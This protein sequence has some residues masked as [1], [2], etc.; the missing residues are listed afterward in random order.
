MK[1]TIRNINLSV[2]VILLSFSLVKADMNSFITSVIP[3]QNAIDINKATNIAITFSQ[4]MNTSTF[5]SSNIKIYGALSGYNSFTLSS[6][7]NSVT[8]NPDSDFA[9]GEDI[10][11]ILNS[12]I[13]SLS[14]DSLTPFGYGFTV[15]ATQGQS[16]FYETRLIK[17]NILQFMTS[18]DIDSDGDIDILAAYNKELAPLYYERAVNVYKRKQNGIYE[19]TSTFFEQSGPNL[20]NTVY[21]MELKDMD[22]DGFLDVVGQTGG[23][24]SF[25]LIAYNDGNGNFGNIQTIPADPYSII[26]PFLIADFD[27]DGDND[28]LNY[29]CSY[30]MLTIY[31]NAGNHGFDIVCSNLIQIGNIDFKTSS[32]LDNDGDIDIVIGSEVILNN[33]NF[34]FTR[35]VNSVPTGF[36]GSMNDFDND[37]DLDL[38]S[39][40]SSGIYLYRNNS[41][42]IFSDSTIIISGDYAFLNIE[43]DFNADGSFDLLLHNN[44]QNKNEI[45]KNNGT[46]YFTFLSQTENLT[47]QLYSSDIDSD[48]DIDIL[49]S[50][51][52]GINALYNDP[53]IFHYARVDSISPH[54]NAVSVYK[55]SNILIY[56]ETPMN[57]STINSSNVKVYGSLTGLLNYSISYEAPQRKV[58]INPNVDFKTGEEITVILNS[59]IKN[60]NGDSL[61][62]ISY[63]FT[64]AATQGQAVFSGIYPLPDT[65]INVPYVKNIITGDIDLDS[66]MDIIALMRID[67]NTYEGIDVYKRQ[68][69]GSYFKTQTF[70]SQFNFE[71]SV[72]NYELKD[73][74]NDGFLD[75]AGVIG[76]GIG[77]VIFIAY[78]NGSGSFTMQ[79]ISAP[80]LDLLIQNLTGDFDNDGDIDIVNVNNDNLLQVYSN[81]G[82]REFNVINLNQNHEFGMN[83]TSYDFD[84]DGDLDIIRNSSILLNNGNFSFSVSANI[85]EGFTGVMKDFDNDGDLDMITSNTSQ[86]FLHRNNG[87]GIFN[88]HIL[89]TS[90]NYTFTNIAEDFNADESYDLLL[91]NTVNSKHEIF[92]NNGTGNFT[93]F[94]ELDFS[95]FTP[96]YGN[97]ID[98]DGDIDIPGKKGNR[99]YVLLNDPTINQMPRIDSLSPHQNAVSVNVSSD[100]SIY[101]STA[102]NASTLNN[103]NIKVYGLQT[104]L[105]NCSIS[106]DAAQKKATINPNNDFKVGER[107]QVTLSSGI[108]NSLFN[109]ISPFTWTFNAQ[110]I[111]GAGEFTEV[112]VNTSEINVSSILSGD[113]DNDGDLDIISLNTDSNNFSVYKNDG[114][115]NFTRTST[116]LV[117]ISS[118]S[119]IGCDLDGD[120]D[121]DIAIAGINAISVYKNNGDAV[122]SDYFD[123]SGIGGGVLSN[124]SETGD[125]DNDGDIDL[126]W[127]AIRTDLI[128][129][130][131]GFIFLNN[132]E[133]T[134]NY[135]ESIIFGVTPGGCTGGEYPGYLKDINII[136][137]DNDG[138]L[139]IAASALQERFCIGRPHV[140]IPYIRIIKNNG[141]SLFSSSQFILLDSISPITTENFDSDEDAD[142][143]SNKLLLR[144]ND[145]G[146]F[147]ASSNTVKGN[148]LTSG[149]FD[150][151]GDLDISA[152]ENPDK[153]F[154]HSNDGNASFTLKTEVGS[155]NNA[156]AMKPGDFDGDG[157]IDIVKLSESGTELSIL[158]NGAC[159]PPICG[160]SGADTVITGST[161]L[162]YLGS[163][164]NAYWEISNYDITQA[165]ILPGQSGDSVKIF[166]GQ[167]AGHFVLYY[168][169]PVCGTYP[170]C[171]KH[172]YVVNPNAISCTIYSAVE[173]FYNIGLNDLNMRDTVS[174]YLRNVNSPY[175][176]VDSARKVIDSLLFG[177]SFTFMNA[178]TGTY[179]LV[180]KHR[181]GL[182]TWSESG[183][184]SLTK[185]GLDYYDFTSSQTQAYGNNLVLKGTKYCLF[186]GDVN[187]NGIIDLTDLVLI[188]NDVSI[189]VS[190][191]VN[192]DVN[193]DRVTDLSDLLIAYNN[194]SN[195]VSLKR[196]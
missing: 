110:A 139:D 162:I 182:E 23:L 118:K 78:N 101:F 45:Y 34:L 188:Y 92:K 51:P 179:Y 103:S 55:S 43:E 174:A 195:F 131:M 28:I 1:K 145:T 46:G 150:A 65:L 191:Y 52:D 156:T 109:S 91:F 20:E 192:S 112:P 41:Q 193:G 66:D 149:D 94:S 165:T 102:M 176:K 6:S 77:P 39:S 44:L 73:M 88:V 160:I 97:D 21:Y 181:N 163:T 24:G 159:I 186:S 83:Y 138:D 62:P 137:F 124:F 60:S 69:D 189:F 180:L 158:K 121:L 89:I 85:P 11:V 106:Y 63:G 56:F 40:N 98:S 153:I 31:S 111:S 155:N 87:Y 47:F 61:P 168:I 196:P 50:K 19:K 37:G 10:F 171:S 33:G 108:Q 86:I 183:G 38:I 119:F 42:G 100:I 54:K 152:A 64:S 12:G 30:N 48:G 185:G 166:A 114:L 71:T 79:N 127:G 57:A 14:G 25:I 143:V 122:F 4:N 134:F 67:P 2:I 35:S 96:Y 177:G 95:G 113:Y 99:I 161:N 22:N 178:P 147:T 115:A 167:N 80:F 173:G 7:V 104:G 130:P 129:E 125:L 68:S 26:K 132:G 142:I 13:K 53:T 72:I 36:S 133:G 135:P 9:A 59:G 120:G 175:N 140:I 164:Q 74:D 93:F 170:S 29:G 107:I 49:G 154:V 184:V 18:G 144:N 90:A 82:N 8:L 76:D 126:F 136:D 84:N 190:G 3:A 17:D 16:V 141:N 117:N 148:L 32:D 5:N 81:I 187:Q 75:V 194:S 105:M 58:T 27:N 169:T 151:D 15:E 70:Y 123:M 146:S 157:D 128:Q 172:I 116:F